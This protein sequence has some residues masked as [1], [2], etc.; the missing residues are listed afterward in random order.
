MWA[1]VGALSISGCGFFGGDE[2]TEADP[3]ADTPGVEYTVSVH[4]APS[5][6]I[7]AIIDESLK[8]NLLKDRPPASLAR[9]RRRA[10]G[11]TEV[12]QKILRAEGYYDAKAEVA[13]AA[14]TAQPLQTDDAKASQPV[15]PSEPNVATKNSVDPEQDGA[16]SEA[17][18]P[19]PA[20]VRIDI[21]AGEIFR[22]TEF[23]FIPSTL[24][25]EAVLPSAAEFGM[26]PT[27]AAK[28]A[29][30]VGVE[31]RVVGW[32]REHGFPYARFVKRRAVADRSTKTLQITSEFDP[33]PLATVNGARIEGLAQVDEAYLRT[34]LPWQENERYARG[35]LDAVQRR[36]AQTGLFEFV[37]VEPPEAPTPSTDAAAS[38]PQSD[39]IAIP[40]IINAE[41][42]K[43][44]TVGGGLRFSTE[45]GPSA[46]AFYEHRNL[47]GSNE[48]TRV[49]ASLGLK[50][51]EFTVGLRKP[52][53]WR[54][55]QAL[56]GGLSLRHEED[57]AFDET[58]LG[59]HLGIERQVT[60]HL[61]LSAG[62]LLEVARIDGANTS[63]TS[64][65][66]GLPF[67][68]VYDRTDNRFDPSSGLRARASLTPYVGAFDDTGLLFSVLDLGASTY[69]AID[70]GK[71][72]ILAGRTRLA[73]LLGA[74]RDDVPPPQRLYSGGGG[75]VR[76]YE[77]RFIGPLDTEDDPIGGR[78]VAEL[79]IELRYRLSESIGIVP[80][81]EAGLVSE[82]I[83]PTTDERI[84][85]A[86]G[87][88]LRYYTAIGPIRAD[89]A[90]P[91][92]PR[93]EDSFFQFYIA[94]GQAF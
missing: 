82:E 59:V 46:G 71:R 54:D 1:A 17:D 18:K 32:L 36:L 42:A 56:F 55:R 29:E 41:E 81:L 6:S 74:G 39:G 30:I 62:T 60:E 72:Y 73:S 91:L 34:Y 84:Q 75:S 3:F 4:G 58:A 21:D 63:G 27:S 31:G 87:L 89:I 50:K 93:D 22:V 25:G 67:T 69:Y 23:A 78:S 26:S 83:Y 92:N 90:F 53:F 51:Q 64:Y 24:P 70:D 35:K 80:F 94:I 45:D 28:S 76:G 10:E 47:F 11:D 38:T 2:K 52:Q 5:K 65:L 49:A 57:E 15:T 61:T 33:G 66:F 12:V 40:I 79:G 9:L 20:S 7:A 68:A 37:T 13:V 86:A 85:Y 77:S 88:G 16:R 19:I 43:H 44:R 14:G 48:T 8:L